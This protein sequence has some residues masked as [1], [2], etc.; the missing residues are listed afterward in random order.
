MDVLMI[1]KNVLKEAAT[2]VRICPDISPKLL[3]NLL[4][5]FKPDECNPPP[6]LKLTHPPFFVDVL[7]LLSPP[8][9]SRSRKRSHNISF[10][11]EPIDTGLLQMIDS[12]ASKQDGSSR[13]AAGDS[14]QEVLFK[15]PPVKPPPV[16][17]N[18]CVAPA[19]HAL[20]KRTHPFR[21]FRSA[22][23]ASGLAAPECLRQ[24]PRLKFLFETR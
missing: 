2:R 18:M 12:E 11:P 17:V 24:R 21:V 15:D 9:S 4:M 1:D 6:P 10:F 8:Q 20:P 22:V 5:M 16:A 14:L 7:F 23:G 19:H 3:L 13:S